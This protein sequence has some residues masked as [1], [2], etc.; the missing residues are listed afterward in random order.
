MYKRQ[1]IWQ[2]IF[3]ILGSLALLGSLLLLIWFYKLGI[4][5]DKNVLT[6][7]VERHHILGPLI[8]LLIQILQVV[9]PIIPGGV[10]TVIGYLVFG[11][12]LGFILNYI[13]ILIGS[14]ILFYLS[15]IYGKRFC[16][17]FMKK[18]TFEKYEA[19]IGDHK[20]YE[21]FFILCML[22]PVSPADVIVMITGLT[23]MSFRRFLSIILVCKPL[24]IISYSYFWIYGSAYLDQFIKFLR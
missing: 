3:Q 13:G 5:N 22:S 7:L 9:F 4:L 6:P 2:K 17:L 8:F 23:H 20:A 10:T 14:I 24:S 15:R 11:P 18:A 21:I 19:K 12:W 1:L 16:L